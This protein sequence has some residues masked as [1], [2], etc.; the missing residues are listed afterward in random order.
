MIFPRRRL[1]LAAP[2]LLLAGRSWGGDAPGTVLPLA[3]SLRDAL[4]G[5]LRQER[6]LVV[7]VSLE[8]CPFCRM[9]RDSHLVP[10][11]RDEGLPVVEVDIHGDMPLADIAGRPTTHRA[12]AQAWKV[13]TA[14]TLLFL[15]RGGAE[16]APRLVGASIP[17]FYGA[18]LEERVRAANLKAARV[19]G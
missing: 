6:A 15:G 4:A 9:V 5:A 18:Y 3:V 14:P 2:A 11:R 12:Q 8:G 19:T 10:M 17:D 1:L 16:V 7:M 13:R